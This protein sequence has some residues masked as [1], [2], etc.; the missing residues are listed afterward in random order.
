MNNVL[1]IIHRVNTIE[2]LKKIE[3]KYG[4][5]IDIRYDN[6]NGRLYLNHDP[7]DGDDFEEYLKIFLERRNRFIIF[8][9][10]EAGIEQEVIDLAAKYKI[11][12]YFLLDVGFPFIF[13][14]TRKRN[15]RKIAFRYS[16]AEPI[17]A[18]E[19]QIKNGKPLVDWVWI[20]TNTMLP[21]DE[22]IIKKLKPF[23]TC[24]VCP[25]RWGRPE[26]IFNYIEKMKKL[27]F[28]LDAVMTAYKH[29]KQWE[30]S[31]VLNE[32]N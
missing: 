21:L 2:D 32:F 31:G 18:V 1:V 16:E 22:N 20:D 17:E 7:G 29:A 13:W 15:F 3:P 8:N 9:I 30:E 26:D 24:L 25:E 6:R 12:N 23:K 28:K 5:E 27:N 10:K 11:E 14:S 4:V 19:A